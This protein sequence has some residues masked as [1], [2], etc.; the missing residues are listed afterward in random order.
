MKLENLIGFRLSVLQPRGNCRNSIDPIWR[1]ANAI[2][3][4]APLAPPPPL[5]PPQTPRL[6]LIINNAPSPSPLSTEA[7]L[8]D[9]EAKSDSSLEGEPMEEDS[10]GV[11]SSKKRKRKPYRPGRAPD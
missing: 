8:L 3:G 2:A 6:S 5:P 10:K 1:V 9:C 11:D 7:E 4:R